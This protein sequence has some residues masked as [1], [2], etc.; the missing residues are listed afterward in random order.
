METMRLEEWYVDALKQAGVTPNFFTSIPYWDAVGWRAVSE[1][2]DT[3][4]V[5]LYVADVEGNAVLPSVVLS[6]KGGGYF[7][8]FGVS[9]NFPYDH[10]FIAPRFKDWPRANFSDRQYIYHPRTYGDLAG[11]RYKLIRKNIAAAQADA[12]EPMDFGNPD[13]MEGSVEEL[14]TEWVKSVEQREWYDPEGFV[15]SFYACDKLFLVGEKTRK[16]YAI[17][18]YDVNWAHVNFRGCLTVQGIR[19]LSE[20]ARIRFFQY[21][22]LHT[23][24]KPVNDGGDLGIEGLRFFK[25]R[26]RPAQIIDIFSME[27]LP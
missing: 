6:D 13:T 14:I 24:P 9:C 18:S 21:L 3:A 15:K 23:D 1:S 2:I 11:S 7:V 10:G 19:G 26:L 8:N 5:R 17:V 27:A 16:L 4:T 12:R 25:D 22:A 20:T